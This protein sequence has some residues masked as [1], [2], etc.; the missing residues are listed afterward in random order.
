VWLA[1]E[2]LACSFSAPPCLGP[3]PHRKNPK[4]SSN[5]NQILIVMADPPSSRHQDENSAKEFKNLHRYRPDRRVLRRR[6][7]PPALPRRRPPARATKKPCDA[8][9][10]GCPT[11]LPATAPRRKQIRGRPGRTLGGNSVVQRGQLKPCTLTLRTSHFPDP[12]A[13][14]I[15]PTNPRLLTQRGA[16]YTNISFTDLRLQY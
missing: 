7:P 14:A 3:R 5:R 6:C 8:S 10:G 2:P 13:A 16:V 15:Q 12:P 11:R 4:P 1:G 9:N